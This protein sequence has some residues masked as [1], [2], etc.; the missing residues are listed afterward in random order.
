MLTYASLYTQS[1]P[2]PPPRVLLC[3]LGCTQVVPTLLAF[4]LPS[5]E[6]LEALIQSGEQR[7]GVRCGLAVVWVFVAAR[8]ICGYI[9]T[10]L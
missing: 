4:S 9:A 10:V 2:P 3:A 5:K 6:L 7:V 8:K 1:L